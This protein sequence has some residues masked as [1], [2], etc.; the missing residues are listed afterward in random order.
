M[1]NRILL[2]VPP[3]LVPQLLFSPLH[4]LLFLPLPGKLCR[5]CCHCRCLLLLLP[6]LPLLLFLLQAGAQR[7]GGPAS[8]AVA[9]VLR[10]GDHQVGDRIAL[11]TILRCLRMWV[12]VSPW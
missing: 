4:L 8:S 7:V 1:H 12:M 6:S 10:L 9:P 11:V 3:L 2:P 5:C